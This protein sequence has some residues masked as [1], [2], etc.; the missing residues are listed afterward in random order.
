MSLKSTKKQIEGLIGVVVVVVDGG[1][2]NGQNQPT[3][4]P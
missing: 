1:F 2:D 3:I 4:T